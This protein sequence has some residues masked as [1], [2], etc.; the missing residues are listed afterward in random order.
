MRTYILVG[1]SLLFLLSTAR[2]ADT[3]SNSVL[4]VVRKFY[5]WYVPATPEGKW[6]G[7][8]A[9]LKERGSSMTNELARALK[10]DFEA[11]SREKDEI[12]GLDFDPFLASQDPCERY[13]VGKA[14][15]KEDRYWVEIYAVCA[16][17]KRDKPDVIAE[18]MPKGGSW[19]FANFRYPTEK[20]DL[21]RVLKQLRAQRSKP[22]N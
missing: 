13:E 6:R 16:G 4:Q 12:V 20:T 5:A 11:Q 17:K 22:G 15:R 9:V 2:A 7:W 10:E 3:E 1:C 19:V 18:L 21:L 14:T 8:D